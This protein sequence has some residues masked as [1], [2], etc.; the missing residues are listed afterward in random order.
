[1]NGLQ[2]FVDE[3]LFFFLNEQKP[4]LKHLCI[5]TLV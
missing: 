4:N 2:L 1:M 3:L 5:I